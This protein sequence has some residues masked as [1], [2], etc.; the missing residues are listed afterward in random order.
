[1]MLQLFETN[2]YIYMLDM[3]VTKDDQ[4]HTSE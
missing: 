4:Y 3:S 2:H 1:M